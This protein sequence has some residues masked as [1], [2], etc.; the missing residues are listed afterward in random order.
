M[1]DEDKRNGK[2]FPRWLVSPSRAPGGGHDR[3][4]R[5]DQRRQANV[6]SADAKAGGSKHRPFASTGTTIADEKRTRFSAQGQECS[7]S[8]PEDLSWSRFSTEDSKMEQDLA[9]DTKME[10]DVTSV[11]G[12][13]I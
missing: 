3:G 12:W 9:E 7:R 2:Y 13:R 11:I 6:R 5:R 1:S 4:E 8:K 10:Q